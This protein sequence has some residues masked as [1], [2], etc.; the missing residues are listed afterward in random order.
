V[1]VTNYNWDWKNGVAAGENFDDHYNIFP[2]PATDI[3]ANP[4]LIQNP[5]Y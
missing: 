3:N 5:E 1:E 4:N 2:I